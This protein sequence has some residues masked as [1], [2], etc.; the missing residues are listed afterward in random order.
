MTQDVRS[1]RSLARRALSRLAQYLR[2]RRAFAAVAVSLEFSPLIWPWM[3]LRRDQTT[4]GQL[5]RLAPRLAWQA[6]RPLPDRV[7]LAGCGLVWPVR[8]W[9][10]GLAAVRRA[11]PPVARAGGPGL[12]RQWRD[13]VAMA[14]RQN[15]S[16]WTYYLFRFWDPERRSR[17]GAFIQPHEL[18]TLLHRANRGLDTRVVTDKVRLFEW[19]HAHQIPTPGIG[20]TF[21]P[22]GGETWPAGTPGVFPSTSLFLKWRDGEQGLGAERWVYDAAQAV[23]TRRGARFDHDQLLAHCR[24]RGRRRPLIVQPCLANHADLARFSTGALCTFRVVTTCDRGASAHLVTLNL[25][26]PRGEAD[27]DNLYGGGITSA[28]DPATGRLSAAYSIDVGDDPFVVHPDTRT[29]ID[30]SVVTRHASAVQLA[31]AAHE[32]LLTPWAIGWDVAVTPDGPM[33][34]EGNPLWGTEVAL[35]EAF[36]TGLLERVAGASPG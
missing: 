9:M 3:S 17:A 6:V 34:I 30:G 28:V 10:S 32:R 4:V 36:A 20:A 27:V 18:A 11:G 23:W 13:A 24:A 8:S 16:P 7:L 5:R 22:G 2:D 33:L 29:R 19:C 31:Q 35:G 21:A 14:N 15:F 1:R 26:M 12:W 25:K